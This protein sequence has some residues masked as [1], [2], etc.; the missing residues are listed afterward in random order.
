MIL[1]DVYALHRKW[2]DWEWKPGAGDTEWTTWDYVLADAFQVI[3]DYTDAESGQ[4]L[5]FDQSGDVYW[6]VKSRISGSLAAIRKAEENR[7]ELKPG[8]SLYAVPV[9]KDENN[10]P[11]LESWL[12]DVAE[13]KND[14][15]P[16]QARDA[17]PPTPEELAAMG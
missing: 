4:W 14:A 15:R 2:W 11:T 12:N 5:P 8:E 17:R 6:D 10:K 1:H 3:E 9:F 16:A 7:K 13:E